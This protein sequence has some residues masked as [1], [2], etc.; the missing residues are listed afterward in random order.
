MGNG[1][2]KTICVIIAQSSIHRI[3]EYCGAGGYFTNIILGAIAS[4]VM[5]L[6]HRAKT[7]GKQNSEIRNANSSHALGFTKSRKRWS[8][9]VGGGAG[10][11]GGAAP[12]PHSS[13]LGARCREGRYKN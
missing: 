4:A 10:K 1:F 3:L 7:S 13:V 5:V 8:F 6:K 11:L 12:Q 2:N 9:V